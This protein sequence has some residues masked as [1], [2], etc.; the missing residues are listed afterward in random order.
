[1]SDRSA[2]QFICVVCGLKMYGGTYISGAGPYCPR[3]VP[4]QAA[5][6]TNQQPDYCL[7]RKT[8]PYST[9]LQESP[10][11]IYP[12]PKARGQANE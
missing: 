2:I 12:Q 7:Y 11:F 10:T 4:T 1:M 8:C 5:I 6:T 9:D 3:C